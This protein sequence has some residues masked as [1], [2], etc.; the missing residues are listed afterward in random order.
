MT[1]AEF[2]SILTAIA[3]AGLALATARIA[4]ATMSYARG[5]NALAGATHEGLRAQAEAA[6]ALVAANED[7]ARMSVRA[8]I[9]SGTRMAW[10]DAVRDAVA[11]LLSLDSAIKRAA[12]NE[13]GAE[14]LDNMV[15][16][17]EMIRHR[18][19]FRLDPEK[20]R[21][22]D[23]LRAVDRLVS[24]T[25]EEP[26][27]SETIRQLSIAISEEEWR[28]VR[29]ELGAPVSADARA[30]SLATAEADLRSGG[31]LPSA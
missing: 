3:T 28:R 21:H 13:V 15:Q 10:V 16:R 25:A 20:N 8:H 27:T 12:A 23:L 24:F 26:S 18:L 7:L 2:T 1:I 14:F 17:R 6:Q 31:S 9:V 29:R 5:T 19:E 30:S 11:E 4:W 22:S